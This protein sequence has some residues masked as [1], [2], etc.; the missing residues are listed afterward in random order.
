MSKKGIRRSK[1]GVFKRFGTIVEAKHNETDDCVDVIAE[2]YP[3]YRKWFNSLLENQKHEMI[4]QLFVNLP[5]KPKSSKK[6]DKI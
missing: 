4:V 1:K 2:I 6:G 5:E 3:E